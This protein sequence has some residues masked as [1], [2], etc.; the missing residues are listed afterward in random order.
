M[1]A[2]RTLLFVLSLG[3]CARSLPATLPPSSAASAAAT[4]APAATVARALRA[5]PPLPGESTAGWEGL[6]P[7]TPAQHGGHGHAH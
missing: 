6:E 2:I 1:H 4:E 5:D 7:S 3:G